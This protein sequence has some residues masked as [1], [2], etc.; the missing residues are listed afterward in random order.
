MSGWMHI[1]LEAYCSRLWSLKK[2][3]YMYEVISTKPLKTKKILNVDY[4]KNYRI[5]KQ[6]RYCPKIAQYICMEKKCPHL[7]TV[8][9]NK[10]D[11]IFLDKRYEKMKKGGKK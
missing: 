3:K 7:A 11:Y 10:E 4:D 5:P 6:P 9:A 8:N 1:I 2:D